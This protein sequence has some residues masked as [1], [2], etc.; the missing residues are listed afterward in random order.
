MLVLNV[1]DLL[2]IYLDF[3][4]MSFLEFLHLG[5]EVFDLGFSLLNF[6]TG[7]VIEVVDHVLFDLNKVTFNLSVR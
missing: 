6:R 1:L 5:I 3:T 7:V 2:D 4:A